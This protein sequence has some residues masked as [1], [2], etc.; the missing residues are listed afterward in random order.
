MVPFLTAVHIFHLSSHNCSSF[1]NTF[2]F[3]T[4]FTLSALS[5]LPLNYH[6]FYSLLLFFSHLHSNIYIFFP[7]LLLPSYSL[8]TFLI[9]LPQ[10]FFQVTI[11]QSFIPSYFTSSPSIFHPPFKLY[12]SFLFNIISRLMLRLFML[13]FLALFQHNFLPSCTHIPCNNFSFPIL[14]L[15]I[16]HSLF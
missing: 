3:G 7:V 14:H 13:S 15:S 1:P 16:L 4:S 8:I 9:S 2:L 6:T 12:S 5:L 10:L 11:W